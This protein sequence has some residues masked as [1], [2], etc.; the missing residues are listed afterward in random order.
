VAYQMDLPK[1][2]KIRDVFHV[3]LLHPYKSD[4][5]VQPPPPSLI[6]GQEEFEVHMMLDHR[7]RLVS[8]KGHKREFLVRWLG[9]G[10]EHDTW[11]P[12][13]NLQNCQESLGRYWKSLEQRQSAHEKVSWGTK[14]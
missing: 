8:T 14:R 13:E 12:E 3:S 9:Y 10:P 11:E 1:E 4:G 7:D 5:T 6:E 2:L